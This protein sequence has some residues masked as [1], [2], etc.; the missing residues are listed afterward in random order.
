MTHFK[1]VQISGCFFGEQRLVTGVIQDFNSVA[2]TVGSEI[3]GSG[4]I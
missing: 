1:T 3:R 2:D 4:H